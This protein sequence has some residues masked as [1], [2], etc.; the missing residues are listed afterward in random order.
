MLTL[1]IWDYFMLTLYIWDYFM[2]TLY[3]WDYSLCLLNN[4]DSTADYI[5]SNIKIT[6]Q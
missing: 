3:I 4:V 2:L 5:A 6:G 1:Y